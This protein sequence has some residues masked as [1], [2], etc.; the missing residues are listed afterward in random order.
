MVSL[1]ISNE[2]SS[3]TSVHS[4]SILVFVSYCMHALLIQHLSERQCIST[5]DLAP[6]N[7]NQTTLCRSPTVHKPITA[8]LK[9]SLQIADTHH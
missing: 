4:C 3:Q 1:G 9:S 2:S 5:N 6:D 8:I 7:H